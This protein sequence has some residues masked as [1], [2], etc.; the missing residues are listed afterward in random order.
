ME[1]YLDFSLLLLFL[2]TWQGCKRK[3]RGMSLGE[4]ALGFCLSWEE[5]VYNSNEERSSGFRHELRTPIMPEVNY[6]LSVSWG[7]IKV[8]LWVF[9]R[10][11]LLGMHWLFN[12]DVAWVSCI[13]WTGNLEVQK[14]LYCMSLT[15]LVLFVLVQKDVESGTDTS[16]WDESLWKPGV[17]VHL[18]HILRW[19]W[20]FFSSS[21]NRQ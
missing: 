13:A 15:R 3:Y 10:R 5:F 1:L 11:T 20:D 4:S 7:Y 16:V 18:Q 8:C 14:Y 19:V 12:M 6:L 2:G 17:R 21:Y 9:N